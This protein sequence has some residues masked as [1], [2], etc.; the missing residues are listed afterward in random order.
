MDIIVNKNAN[1]DLVF[2]MRAVTIETQNG[3][4]EIYPS[5]RFVKY[6][7]CQN[8]DIHIDYGIIKLL[9]FKRKTSIEQAFIIDNTDCF[10]GNSLL[11]SM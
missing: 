10:V 6:T 8:R 11:F 9:V 3:A 4:T 7:R 1:N 2:P 5:H